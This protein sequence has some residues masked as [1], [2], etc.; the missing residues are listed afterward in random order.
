M[1]D[2]MSSITRTVVVLY[3]AFFVV[4]CLGAVVGEALPGAA[5]PSLLGMPLWFVVSCL[6]SFAGV[7]V[8]LIHC[9][10]GWLQ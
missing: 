3:L 10:R 7:A 4:W 1:E 8:A 9:V 6:L 5:Q 2:S